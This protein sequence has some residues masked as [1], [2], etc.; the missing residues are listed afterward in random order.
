V[1]AKH[2]VVFLTQPFAP[3]VRTNIV[4]LTPFYDASYVEKVH[5][6]SLQKRLVTKTDAALLFGKELNV[7]LSPDANL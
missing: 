5:A 4:L 6:F 3:T 2:P 7:S 1:S